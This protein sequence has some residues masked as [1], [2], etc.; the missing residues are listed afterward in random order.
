MKLRHKKGIAGTV[1]LG[2][3]V[4]GG[5]IGVDLAVETV[6]EE[7]A[8]YVREMKTIERKATQREIS[9]LHAVSNLIDRRAKGDEPTF[10]EWLAVETA[11]D[12]ERAVQ[13]SEFL[14]KLDRLIEQMDAHDKSIRENA[15]NKFMEHEVFK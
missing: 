3:I 10:E 4:L 7:S 11:I 6:P 14:Q 13:D 9:H 2:T 15:V 5:A 1:I 12:D 8:R